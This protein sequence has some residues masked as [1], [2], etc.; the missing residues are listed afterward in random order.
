MALTNVAIKNASPRDKPYRLYDEKGLYLEITPKGTKLWRWKYRFNGK[1][2]RLAIGPFPEIGLQPARDIRDT[3]RAL[4]ASGTDPSAH[5]KAQKLAGSSNADSNFEALARE[6]HAGKSRIWSAVHSK[7]VLD[8]LSRNVFPFIGQTS[9]EA[10]TVPEVLKLLRRIEERG[11]N[12]TAHR[13]LGNIGEVYRYAIASGKAERNIA[14]DIKGALQPVKKRHLAAITEPARVGELLRMIDGYSGTLTVQ[15]AFKLAPLT[16]VRPGELRKALW[17][18]IDLDTA[19]WRFTVTKTKTPHIVPLSQQAIAILKTLQPVTAQ[20][21]YVFPNRRSLRRPMSDNAILSALR[22]MDIDKSEMSGH[23]FRAMART[24]LDEVLGIR[25][26]II[27]HQLSHAVRDPLGRA[28]N[29][30][31]HLSERRKM[32]QKWA[33]YLEGLKTGGYVQRNG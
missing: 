31:T 22:R 4:L 26:E 8:R 15:S 14:V 20:S 1:E 33:D 25:P 19:E 30:T 17:S 6:W 7:N 32:M 29:R 13:V 16:F 24:I 28:Y 3:A 10:V 11:A 21:E 27:E 9:I 18:E 5:K 12:E 2:K 23:G